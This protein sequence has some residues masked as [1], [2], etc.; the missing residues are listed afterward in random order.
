MQRVVIDIPDKKVPFFMEL[1][2]N[3][4][5]K[6][7]RK[8]S[9]KQKTFVDD[10]KLSLTEVDSHQNGELKLQSARDFIHEL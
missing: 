7:V 6:K 2:G 5:L 9:L 8:L 4:G 3:L 10:V 1:I